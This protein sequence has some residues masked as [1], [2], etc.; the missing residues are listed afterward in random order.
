MDPCCFHKTKVERIWCLLG[1]LTMWLVKGLCSQRHL[2][3]QNVK[4]PCVPLT[5]RNGWSFKEIWCI[6]IIMLLQICFRYIACCT[7]LTSRESGQCYEENTHLSIYYLSTLPY[8]VILL[9]VESII[10]SYRKKGWSISI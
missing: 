10:Y 1:G 8:Q 2:T 5:K 9:P 6:K 7:T 4:C 3:N